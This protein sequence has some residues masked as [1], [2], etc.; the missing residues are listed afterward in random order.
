MC[1]VID[2]C[3]IPAVFDTSNADH[4]ELKPIY[5][6]IRA[7][8][9]KMVY[10]GTTYTKELKRLPT[11]QAIIAAYEHAGKVYIVDKQSVD[12]VEKEIIGKIANPSFNDY[13]LAAILRVSKS[14]ILCSKNSGHF[15]HIRNSVLYP[16]KMKKPYVYRNSRDIAILSQRDVVRC[17]GPCK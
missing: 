9:G 3:A 10:G 11:F 5:D 1:V 7:G 14:R 8:K 12:D 6:W 13:H 16:Q 2:V 15:V 17:C 4:I